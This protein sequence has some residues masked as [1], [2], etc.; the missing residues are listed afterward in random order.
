MEEERERER[1]RNLRTNIRPESA[2]L[3]DRF[4][5]RGHDTQYHP[6]SS[7]IIDSAALDPVLIQPGRGLTGLPDSSSPS[8]GT[9]PFGSVSHP[10]ARAQTDLNVVYIQD[11]HNTQHTHRHSCRLFV[12]HDTIHDKSCSAQ[13]TCVAVQ[14]HKVLVPSPTEQTASRNSWESEVGSRHSS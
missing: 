10:R 6:P 4:R 14:S 7:S 9:A 3:L 12:V 1:E 5:P 2:L 13:P 8:D 11:T